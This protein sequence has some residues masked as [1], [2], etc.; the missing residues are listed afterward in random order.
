VLTASGLGAGDFTH[1]I[2]DIGAYPGSDLAGTRL[3]K[4]LAGTGLSLV[5]ADG[6]LSRATTTSCG[7]QPS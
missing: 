7:L 6:T 3:T 2:V 1:L 5:N 4:I